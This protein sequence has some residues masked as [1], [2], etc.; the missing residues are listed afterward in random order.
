MKKC[1]VLHLHTR[2]F[3]QLQKTMDEVVA[4]ESRTSKPVEEVQP[5]DAADQTV[6]EPPAV[7]RAAPAGELI[8]KDVLHLIDMDSEAMCMQHIECK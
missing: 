8:I 1:E 4:S 3:T 2:T 5:T 6:V 7:E